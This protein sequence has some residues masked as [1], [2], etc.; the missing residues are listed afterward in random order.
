V[1]VS[2][3]VGQGPRE[4]SEQ[5][6]LARHPVARALAIAGDQ[7]SSMPDARAVEGLLASARELMLA[8]PEFVPESWSAYVVVPESVE[9]WQ[10]AAGRNQV[11]LR[12]RRGAAGDSWERDLIWP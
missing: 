11:R 4:V 5:D 6:F 3:E 8:D 2:G 10:A 1:R 12:Y 9:F 7:S